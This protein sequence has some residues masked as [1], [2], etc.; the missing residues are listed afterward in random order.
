MRLQVCGGVSRWPS[1]GIVDPLRTLEPRSEV[2]T[3]PPER[4]G[5]PHC[6]ET[7]PECQRR[8]MPP[9]APTFLALI[10]HLHST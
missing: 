4:R 9:V 8:R 5:V 10:E 3:L 7:Q 6:S 1:A 2:A